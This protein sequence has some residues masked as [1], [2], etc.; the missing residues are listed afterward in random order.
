MRIEVDSHT[1]HVIGR[2]SLLNKK[3]FSSFARVEGLTVSNVFGWSSWQTS[4]LRLA[5][6]TK[7]RLLKNTFNRKKKGS[8]ELSY[9]S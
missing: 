6:A 4:F 2:T 5:I 1:P 9:L 8:T 7:A 3:L